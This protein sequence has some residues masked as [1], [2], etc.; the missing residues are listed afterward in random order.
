MDGRKGYGLFLFSLFKNN[1]ITPKIVEPAR[2][3]AT[4]KALKIIERAMRH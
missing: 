1:E 3:D 4:V 2:I